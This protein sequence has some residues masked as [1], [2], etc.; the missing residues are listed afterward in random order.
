ML[1]FLMNT[2]NLFIKKYITN[3]TIIL[4]YF[5]YFL[6]CSQLC[7]TRTKEA[8]DVESDLAISTSI[9]SVSAGVAFV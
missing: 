7:L 9:G 1:I 8:K 3:E 6:G 2:S 5:K 4:A